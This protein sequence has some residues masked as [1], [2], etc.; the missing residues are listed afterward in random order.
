VD[1]AGISFGPQ[2]ANARDSMLCLKSLPA[3]FYDVV[4]TSILMESIVTFG[5]SIKVGTPDPTIGGAILA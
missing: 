2:Q 3:P 4:V 5:R 1:W